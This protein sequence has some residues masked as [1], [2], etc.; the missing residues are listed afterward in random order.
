MASLLYNCYTVQSAFTSLAKK[1][2][3]ASFMFKTPQ[4]PFLLATM[5]I[6]AHCE[7]AKINT[8]LMIF[9]ISYNLNKFLAQ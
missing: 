9:Y 8:N 7:K 1:L 3:I 6:N 2:A 5:F 4:V